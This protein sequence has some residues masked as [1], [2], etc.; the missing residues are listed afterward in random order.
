M[1]HIQQV[2]VRRVSIP[3]NPALKIPREFGSVPDSSRYSAV[4][5]KGAGVPVVT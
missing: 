5:G 3:G 2:W 1:A 4:P